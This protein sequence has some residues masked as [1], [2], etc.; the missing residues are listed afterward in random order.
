LVTGGT[1]FIGSH[2]VIELLESGY[3]VV[4]VD[5]LS[6]SSESLK[7]V[8]GIAG[9]KVR[10]FHKVDITDQQALDAVFSAYAGQIKAVIHLAGLKSVG[11]SVSI[12]LKYY[13]NNVTGTCVLL[14]LMQK[15]NVKDIVFSSSATVYGAVEKVPEGGLTEDSPTGATNPYGRTKLFIEGIIS[16]VHVS[17]PSWNAVI[18]RYFN[19]VGAHPCGKIGE[20]PQGK[21]NNLCPFITQVAVGKRP[22]LKIFGNNYPTIDGTGVRD[23]IHVVDLAKG[24]IS[25][26]KHLTKNPGYVVYNLGTGKGLSV[27]E[28]V[29]AMKKASGREIPYEFA[30]RR[31]GD[32]AACTASPLKAERELGWKATL[33]VERMC[34]DAW[35]WQSSHPDGF[36]SKS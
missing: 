18:L 7:I 8:E 14:E 5:N 10:A 17:D 1:G 31:P 22:V 21:P 28:M 12:P 2:I 16:D 13:R 33:G 30:D 23:Y 3:E 24:H 35:R 34:E 15:Y 26:L 11:E 4:V 25:A 27:L 9:K 20:D 6:N 36:A 32:I 19:P 29:N